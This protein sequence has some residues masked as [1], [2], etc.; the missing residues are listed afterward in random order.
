M[1]LTP[2]LDFA[3]PRLWWILAL[4]GPVDEHLLVQYWHSQFLSLY[5]DFSTARLLHFIVPNVVSMLLEIVK[6]FRLTFM[7]IILK[8]PS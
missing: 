3:S 4:L 1:F 2:S 7:M 5:I 8:F 6:F